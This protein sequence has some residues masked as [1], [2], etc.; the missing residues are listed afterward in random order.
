MRANLS[1]GHIEMHHSG[2]FPHSL[3]QA[4]VSGSTMTFPLPEKFTGVNSTAL[5][6]G[7]TPSEDKGPVDG[8]LMS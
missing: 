7:V 1:L 6:T 8:H 2:P 4:M 5:P 3:Q